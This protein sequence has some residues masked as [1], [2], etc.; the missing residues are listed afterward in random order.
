[1]NSSLI[2]SIEEY[3]WLYSRL[4]YDSL[5]LVSPYSSLMTYCGELFKHIYIRP[6]YSPTKPIITKIKPSSI[7]VNAISELQPAKTGFPRSLL[8]IMNNINLS[9]SRRNVW[10]LYMVVLMVE[11]LPTVNTKDTTNHIICLILLFIN[12]TSLSMQ[13][14]NIN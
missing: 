7:R 1:M 13:V 14:F 2:I 4:F 9:E 12:N 10:F 11:R 5:R 6:M 8:A 3:R